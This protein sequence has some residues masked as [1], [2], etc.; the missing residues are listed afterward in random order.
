MTLMHH[1]HVISASSVHHQCIISSSSSYDEQIPSTSSAHH[2][3]ISSAS[4]ALHKPIISASSSSQT[5]C[6][7]VAKCQGSPLVA[8]RTPLGANGSQKMPMVYPQGTRG[9][10]QAPMGPLRRPGDPHLDAQGTIFI[11]R[12]LHVLLCLVVSKSI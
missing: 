4:S 10:L 2:Q 1:Q 3:C 11:H 6:S 8:Q 12:F 9:P 7:F 5:K